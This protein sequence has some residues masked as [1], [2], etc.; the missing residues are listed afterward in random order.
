MAIASL[1][2]MIE[3]RRHQIWSVYAVSG[4]KSALPQQPDQR[5]AVR[6]NEPGGV[7]SPSDGLVPRRLH[8]TMDAGQRHV[9]PGSFP[10]PPV[11]L[12]YRDRDVYSADV[13]A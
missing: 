12:G 6:E 10:D 8:D 11:D 3:Q 2:T 4:P 13:Y 9:A 7:V 1:L 5:H